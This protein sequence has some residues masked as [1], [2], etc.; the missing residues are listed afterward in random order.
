MTRWPDMLSCHYFRMWEHGRACSQEAFWLV[1]KS[2]GPACFVCMMLC[3]YSI[4][5]IISTVCSTP[6]EAS[7]LLFY[8]LPAVRL[9]N[10]NVHGL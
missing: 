4:L 1:R 5:L 6:A 8:L 2:R 7:F 3:I 9:P 10:H